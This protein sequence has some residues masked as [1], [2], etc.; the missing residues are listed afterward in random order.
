MFH[1]GC[2]IGATVTAVK[3]SIILLLG[4]YVS[5]N[6]VSHLGAATRYSGSAGGCSGSEASLLLKYVFGIRLTPWSSLAQVAQKVLKVKVKAKVF[7]VLTRRIAGK[8]RV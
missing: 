5:F 7:L 2:S 4:S 3:Q 6:A 8:P 1:K